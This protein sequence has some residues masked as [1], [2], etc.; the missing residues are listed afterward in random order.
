M[1]GFAVEHRKMLQKTLYA[2]VKKKKKGA[3]WRRAGHCQTG[4]IKPRTVIKI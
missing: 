3:S 2:R 1:F 4:A